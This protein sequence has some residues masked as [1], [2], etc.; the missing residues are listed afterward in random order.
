[1]LRTLTLGQATEFGSEVILELILSLGLLFDLQVNR[2]RVPLDLFDP[3]YD[4]VFKDLLPVFDL[5]DSLGRRWFLEGLVLGVSAAAH[6]EKLSFKVSVFVLVQAIGVRED[7]VVAALARLDG[8]H[9]PTRI[10]LQGVLAP[11]GLLGQQVLGVAHG[12]LGPQHTL[13]TR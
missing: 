2:L 4:L 1:M 8:S 13:S 6:H 5:N 7:G 9:A 12:T 10:K 11:L 3:L